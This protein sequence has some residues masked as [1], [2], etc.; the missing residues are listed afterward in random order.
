ME[1]KR[2]FRAVTC[3]VAGDLLSR[4]ARA[5]PARAARAVELADGE[6]KIRPRGRSFKKIVDLEPSAENLDRFASLLERA[7]QHEEEA[8]VLERLVETAG[9]NDDLSLRLATAYGKAGQVERA[10]EQ[11]ERAVSDGHGSSRVRE[12]LAGIYRA[13]LAWEPLAK[14]FHTQADEAEDVSAKVERLREA[15]NI[16]I[17]NLRDANAAVPPGRRQSSCCRA[18]LQSLLLSE[19]CA[20]ASACQKRACAQPHLAE[21]GTR[22]RRSARWCTSSRQARARL[23]RLAPPS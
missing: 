20:W 21:F 7:E 1:N 14:L 18:A 13:A 12:V 4:R 2:A 11:L 3:S 15:A 23:E 10:R 9:E 22:K 8:V 19:P 16:Y 17:H 5:R 6:L